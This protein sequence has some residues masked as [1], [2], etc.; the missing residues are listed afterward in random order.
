MDEQPKIGNLETVLHPTSFLKGEREKRPATLLLLVSPKNKE[1]PQPSPYSSH[2]RGPPPFPTA[3]TS[4]AS[5]YHVAVAPL[6]VRGVACSPSFLSLVLCSLK[7]IPSI[8][9]PLFSNKLV[10]VREMAE[11][12]ALRSQI[13]EIQKLCIEEELDPSN[14]YPLLEE[15]ALHV[16]SRVY[17]ALAESSDLAYLNE[18][19]FDACMEHLKEE[20]NKVEAES[21]N[22]AKEIEHLVENHN[23]DYNLLQAKLEQIKCSLDYVT[24]KDQETE[25]NS[26]ATD[27]SV[28]ADDHTTLTVANLDTYLEYLQLETEVHEMKS[29]VESSEDLQCKFKWFDAVNQ[30]EDAF[31]GLKVL[32]FE[33]NCIRL[34]LRTYMP[35]LEGLSCLSRLQDTIDVSELNHELLIEVY[36]G[37]LKLKN[38]QVFPNNIHVSDIVDNAKSLSKSSLQSFI[39]KVQDRII[40]STLRSLVVKDANKSRHMFEYLDKDETI[41]AHIAGGVEAYIKLS[42]GWPIFA[43]PLTLISVKGSDSLRGTSLS[44][45]ANVEKLANSLDDDIRLN[46]LSFADAVEK[47]LKE[48][49]AI[50]SSSR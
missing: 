42:H 13:E 44:F 28:L 7:I 35:K 24:S 5:S 49:V 6:H 15:C 32:A 2:R 46:I 33:D 21:T 26:E 8:S 40:L 17:Q 41:V 43:S 11:A 4:N 47:V 9:F 22:V 20:L 25:D 36:E 31:T 18:Q 1:E 19:D 3:L 12:S 27:S 45:H 50:G 30:I 34:S 48:A 16:Q 37:T 29:V 23:D 10:A 39:T 38:V 14:A